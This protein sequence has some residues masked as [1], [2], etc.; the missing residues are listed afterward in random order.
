MQVSVRRLVGVACHHR[1]PVRSCGPGFRLQPCRTL[2]SETGIWEKDYRPENR[3][4]VEAWWQPRIMAQAQRGTLQQVSWSQEELWE[5]SAPL[6]TYT[7]VIF[8]TGNRVTAGI[9]VIT[10]EIKTQ[11]HKFPATHES[12]RHNIFILILFDFI[13]DMMMYK[14]HF[15]FQTKVQFSLWQ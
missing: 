4:R 8:R 3:R 11:I 7:L 12:I 13:N 5:T 2:F 6:T 15:T 9:V 10:F 14:T 1:C